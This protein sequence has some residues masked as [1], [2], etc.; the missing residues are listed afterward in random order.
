MKFYPAVFFLLTVSKFCSAQ[1]LPDHDTTYYKSFAKSLFGRFYFSQ[2]YTRFELE[3]DAPVSRFVYK[4]NTNLNMGVGFTYQSLTVNL[5]YGFGFL[6]PDR[7]KGKT[8]YIDLQSHIFGR[9]WSIDLM[10][11]FYKGYYLAPKGLAS[12]SAN[13][14][15]IRPDIRLNIMGIAG[16][17]LFNPQKFSYRAAFVQNEWQKKSAGSFLAGA[18]V[19]YGVIRGDSSL[20][21]TNLQE[22]YA[23]K[24]VKNLR[25]VRIGPGMGYAHTFVFKKS[26]FFTASLTGSLGVEFTRQNTVG[27]E[28]DKVSVNPGYIYRLVGGYNTGNINFSLSLI[29]NSLIV[30][31]ASSVN[32]YVISAGN[33]R[34]TIAKRFTPG[35]K[36]KRKLR[37]LDKFMQRK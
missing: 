25:F 23:Q 33:Y 21:P 27:G 16:Y 17:R 22:N 18:E 34:L 14:Y 7:D 20:V 15:Y 4:P 19:Y 8:K 1:E 10:G 29:G 35:P 5:G 9:K 32:K 30:K 26:L 6:N 12:N 2:K 24:D 3:R 13:N 28:R 31:S 11:Q 37:P 36:L